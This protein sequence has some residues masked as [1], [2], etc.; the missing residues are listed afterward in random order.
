MQKKET[1][2]KELFEIE[3]ISEGEIIAKRKKS[4]HI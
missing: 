4:K 2:I 1:N 3:G